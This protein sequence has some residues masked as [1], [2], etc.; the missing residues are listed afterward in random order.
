MK[1]CE[2]IE[3]NFITERSYATQFY[4]DPPFQTFG[5]TSH[6]YPDSLGIKYF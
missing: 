5:P 4:N 2:N 6:K 3:G 1:A